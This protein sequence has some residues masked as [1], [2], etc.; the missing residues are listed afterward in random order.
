MCVGGASEQEVKDTF[1]LHQI[2]N[3]WPGS[4]AR[5]QRPKRWAGKGNRDAPSAKK[6]TDHL[7]L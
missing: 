1:V 4:S 6:H 2:S 3:R 7:D 5:G